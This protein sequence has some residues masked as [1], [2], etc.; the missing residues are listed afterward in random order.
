MKAKNML[1]RPYTPAYPGGLQQYVVNFEQAYALTDQLELSQAQREEQPARINT[2]QQRK[3]QL[4]NCLYNELSICNVL[5][6]CIVAKYNFA[7][8]IKFLA[9]EAHVVNYYDQTLA[10]TKSKSRHAKLSDTNVNPID[11]LLQAMMVS[12]LPQEYVLNDKL[13]QCIPKEA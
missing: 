1:S 2:D 9:T 7:Q 8:M 12:Q 13:Y 10:S 3:E 4:I 11:Q 6:T 5:C